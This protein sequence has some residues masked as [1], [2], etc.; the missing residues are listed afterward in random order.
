MTRDP[1]PESDEEGHGD[2]D[3]RASDEPEKRAPERELAL[4]GRGVRTALRN[5]AT[6]YGFSISITAVYGLASGQHGQDSA[7]GTV[8]FALGAVVGFLV[9]GGVFVTCFQRGSLGEGGQVMTIGGA[10]DVLAVT[11]AIASGFG[12]SRVPVFLGW[13]LTG[14]GTVA[15]YLVIGGLDVVLARWLAKHTTFGRSQ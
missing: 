6:A 1:V 15:A 14:F 13:P 8:A 4:Y 7:W 2:P 11:A 3:S 10:A 5:N 9:V 12:L